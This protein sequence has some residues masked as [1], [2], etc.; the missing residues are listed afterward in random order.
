[1][2]FAVKDNEISYLKIPEI[3]IAHS[4]KGINTKKSMVVISWRTPDLYSTSRV[5]GFD[6]AP[7]NWDKRYFRKLLCLAVTSQLCRGSNFSADCDIIY[8]YPYKLVVRKSL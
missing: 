4:P 8:R 2:I 1:M 6:I 7:D 3:D 5:K